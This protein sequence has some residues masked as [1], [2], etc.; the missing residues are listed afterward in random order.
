MRSGSDINNRPTPDAYRENTGKKYQW[1]AFLDEVSMPPVPDE[2]IPTIMA[3]ITR[4]VGEDDET[5]K[6]LSN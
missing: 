1:R 3:A 2:D 4:A 6:T 5:D